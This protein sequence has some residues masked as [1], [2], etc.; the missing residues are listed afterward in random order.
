MFY[1]QGREGEREKG[2]VLVETGK[3]GRAS[4]EECE[5]ADLSPVTETPVNF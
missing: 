1:C 4:K 2:C 3:C 5:I